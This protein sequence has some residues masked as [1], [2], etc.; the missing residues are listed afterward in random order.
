[1]PTLWMVTLLWSL[2]FS[3]A[4]AEPSEEPEQKSACSDGVAEVSQWLAFLSS[5]GDAVGL[6]TESLRLLY[7]FK[8][9]GSEPSARFWLATAHGQLSDWDAAIDQVALFTSAAPPW[10]PLFRLERARLWGLREPLVGLQLF[11][12]AAV[13]PLPASWHEY[14]A[15]SQLHLSVQGGDLSRARLLA[16]QDSAASTARFVRELDGTRWKKPWVAT[17]LSVLVP[18]AGQAYSGQWGE[19][20]SALV[21]NGLFGW[22]L[23]HNVRNDNESAAVVIGLFAAGFYGGNVYGGAD[24]AVR[25]NRA[26]RDRLLGILSADAAIPARP[27]PCQQTQ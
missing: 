2:S 27:V 20:A 3:A 19:A 23:W 14:V 18:G 10:G 26:Q 15:R 17:L 7:S 16:S 21:V 6:Q 4:G 8:G 9:L 24:A 5:Q 25:R 12:V 1:M 11:D 22:A 13:G